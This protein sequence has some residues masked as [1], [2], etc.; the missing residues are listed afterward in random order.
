MREMKAMGGWGVVCT[1]N[2]EISDDADISPYPALHLGHDR[3]IV[4]Q[5]GMVARVMSAIGIEQARGTC[6]SGTRTFRSVFG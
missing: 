6:G 3:D 1:E 4:R 5:A 2:I